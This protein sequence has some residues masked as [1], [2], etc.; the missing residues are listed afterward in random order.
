MPTWNHTPH[1]LIHQAPFRAPIL[2][3]MVDSCGLMTAS[4]VVGGLITT[5]SVHKQ[6][7]TLRHLK[8]RVGFKRVTT[9][10]ATPLYKPLKG[11]IV[12]LMVLSRF[13]CWIVYTESWLT[14]FKVIYVFCRAIPLERR[15]L[16]MLQWLQ[17]PDGE[18]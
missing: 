4:R 7:L 8:Q 14:K 12:Q 6:P 3:L 13:M 2:G 16:T 11:E 10:Q 5:Q 15:I 1:L 18:R 17:L 9:V